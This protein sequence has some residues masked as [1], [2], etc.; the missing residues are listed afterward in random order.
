MS[1]KYGQNER[2]D[3]M[4]HLLLRYLSETEALAVKFVLRGTH[5]W[6][7]VTMLTET[8]PCFC[9]TGPINCDDWDSDSCTLELCTVRAA[10]EKPLKL[11]WLYKYQ[12][13]WVAKLIWYDCR[14]NTNSISISYPGDNL[15][16]T[17]YEE[18]IASELIQINPRFTFD[19]SPLSTKP[20]P[21]LELLGCNY[22]AYLYHLLN[23]Q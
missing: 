9:R 19:L 20:A 23:W 16:L 3:A 11:K 10:G 12:G 22:H 1:I 6:L 4:G 5:S 17:K 15:Y 2:C 21:S 14:F 13:L 18:L 8:S 7:R